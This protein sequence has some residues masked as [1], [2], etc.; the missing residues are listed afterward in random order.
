MTDQAR[1]A[2]LDALLVAVS[3]LHVAYRLEGRSACVFLHQSLA[4]HA[5]EGTLERIV[6]DVRDECARLSEFVVVEA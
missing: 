6:A 4:L 5:D 2:L 1:S 3:R